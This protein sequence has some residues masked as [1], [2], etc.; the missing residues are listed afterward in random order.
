[1]PQSSVGE[2]QA[3]SRL[4]GGASAV[5]SRNRTNNPVKAASHRFAVFWEFS[6]TLRRSHDL[7]KRR[8]AP[9]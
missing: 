3:S 7:T 6:F 4:H 5:M 2:L 1:M 8:R 9:S